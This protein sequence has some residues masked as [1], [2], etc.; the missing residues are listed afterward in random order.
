MKTLKINNVKPLFN[1]I[2]TSCNVYDEDKE[3][4]GVITKTKGAIK[5]YQTV[6]AIGST[7]RDVKVG[8]IVMINPKRYVV[9][10]HNEKRDSIKGVIG[11]NLTFG[12]DFPMI[13]FNDKMHLLIYDQDVDYIIEGEE[14][15]EVKEHKSSLILPHKT[16]IIV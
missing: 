7:V 14:V 16:N 15:E 5:E 8:D 10:K 13:E 11:D 12:V 2:L 4:G 9:P 1:K 6:I 3:V